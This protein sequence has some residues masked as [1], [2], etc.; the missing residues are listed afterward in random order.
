MIFDPGNKSKMIK[1]KIA[2]IGAGPA[3][4]TAA[5]LLSKAGQDV[6][7]FETDPVYVGGISRTEKYKGNYFDIGGHRFFSKSREVEDFWTEILGDDMLERPRSSRIYYN[8]QFFTYPLAAKEAL[9]KLGIYESCACVLSYMRAKIWPIKNPLNFEDWVTNQ[10]GK[11]LFNI[12]FKSYTEKV[13]GIPCNEISADW[14]AQRIKGL[15]LSSAIRNA[16]FPSKSRNKEKK[17]KTLIDSFRYPR[18]GPGMMWE[19]CAAKCR[20]MGA[21]I[22]M[23]SRIEKLY[24]EQNTWTLEILNG[25]RIKGFDEV[26]SSAPIRELIPAISPALNEQALRAAKSLSYRDFITVVLILTER[27]SF[28]DNWIYIH[29]PSVKVGRIQNFK[30]WSPEM[31]DD[32]STACYGLEYFCF[33]GDGLWNSGDDELIS[34]GKKELVQIGLARNED[35]LDG[36]VVRQ[37]KAY[38][39]YDYVYKQNIETIKT[40]IL[41]YPGLQLVGRN[42]MHKYNNQDHSMMTAML[43]VKNILAGQV[44]FNLW[45]VN[46]DAIYH[47]LEEAEESN[48]QTKGRLIPTKLSVN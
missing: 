2:I 47:E 45:N 21:S 36:Y 30:S 9:K 6:T 20:E 44:L 1:K 24:R 41:E 17:I 26:I 19:A 27:N 32:P 33:D 15:S 23:N 46:E 29:D 40:A 12:F 22:L 43:A 13:W 3:G 31:V 35:F 42:G 7:V 5:Y 16:I 34:L 48:V 37:K 38:P 10:F 39:V 28:S 11:R 25:S 14:A 18:K 4:L 8:N